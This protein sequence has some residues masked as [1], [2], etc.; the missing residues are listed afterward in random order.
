MSRLRQ[1]LARWRAALRGSMTAQIWLAITL[2]ATL[3]VAGSSTLVL[4]LS[5]REL[6]D[7]ADV[8]LLANLAYL[9]Q[10][11]TDEHLLTSG[12]ATE[13]ANRLESQLGSL[14]VALLDEQRRLIAASDQFALPLKLL[15][16]QPF[17]A[18]LLPK[19][20]TT[21]KVRRLQQPGGLTHDVTTADGRIFRLLLGRV[22]LPAAQPDAPDSVLVVLALD[23][24]PARELTTRSLTVIGAALLLS[25]LTAGMVGMRL[26]RRITVAAHRLGGAAGRISGDALG[27]RLAVAELP[28][29]L[30]DTGE[31]F[32]H[33]LD[34][35]QSSFNRLSEFTSDMAHD[36]R[37]PINNLLGEAQVALSRPRSALEYRAVLESAVEDYERLTRLI[38]NMLFL[39]RADD[40]QARLQREWIDAPSF[41]QRVGEYFEPLAE[42][43]GL[44]LLW[45]WHGAPDQPAQI[46]ADRGLLIRAV[47][48]LI[49]NALRYAEPGSTVRMTVTGSAQGAT[50]LAVRNSGPAIP[51]VYHRKIFER[52]FRVD[53]ARERSAEGSGLG[54]AIVKSVMDLHGGSVT[55]RSAPGSDTVFT[56]WFP[57]AVA[58]GEPLPQDPAAGHAPAPP[59]AAG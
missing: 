19:R 34:R 16:R 29:E 9:Q 8:V 11:L 50:R 44:R 10:E 12:G 25:A 49:D 37:T 32:N 30:R 17:S 24:T 57:P 55:V 7:V 28:L 4:R 15:P 33:M 35:L 18:V 58:T 23:A 51:E 41:C 53:P 47:A 45:D 36:L 46:W 13:L 59:P 54:L 42:D 22:A 38:E 1:A 40:R 39:A 26:A 6:G 3:L 43:R 21:D 31:A 20:I 48:N 14:H 27:E 56:L 52:L 5:K 2:M